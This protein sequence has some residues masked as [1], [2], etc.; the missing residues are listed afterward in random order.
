MMGASAANVDQEVPGKKGQF[1]GTLDATLAGTSG[2]DVTL[3]M[4]GI[5]PND[6]SYNVVGTLEWTGPITV[7]SMRTAAA[8]SKAGNLF[9]GGGAADAFNLQLS[10]TGIKS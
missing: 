9:P 8:G 10:L 3:P 4:T 7:P 5:P 1:A 6:G 2:A